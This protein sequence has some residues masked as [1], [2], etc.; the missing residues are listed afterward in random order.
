MTPSAID[1]Q[2]SFLQ[3]N[4]A[5]RKVSKQQKKIDDEALSRSPSSLITNPHENVSNINPKEQELPLQGKSVTHDSS[6]QQKNYKKEEDGKIIK[7]KF[8]GNF[9]DVKI[10]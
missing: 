2:N 3:I 9:L 1:F 4:E 10:D 8:K 6:L 5:K 7:E